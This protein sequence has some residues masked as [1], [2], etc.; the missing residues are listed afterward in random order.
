M[1]ND[2]VKAKEYFEAFRLGSIGERQSRF[3]LFYTRDLILR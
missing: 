1:S 3:R 2:P